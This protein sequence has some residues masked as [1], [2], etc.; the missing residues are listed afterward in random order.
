MLKK[1]IPFKYFTIKVPID[2]PPIET[3]KEIRKAALTDLLSLKIYFLCKTKLIN[4]PTVAEMI[5]DVTGENTYL[6][7]T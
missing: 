2:I 6:T 7:N 3:N 5:L 4:I 1:F